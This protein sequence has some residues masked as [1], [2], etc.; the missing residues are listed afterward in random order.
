MYFKPFQIVFDFCGSFGP[1]ILLASH[2]FAHCGIFIGN[3]VTSQPGAHLGTLGHASPFWSKKYENSRQKRALNNIFVILGGHAWPR[4]WPIQ[5][6]FAK[7]TL[8]IV[9]LVIFSDHLETTCRRI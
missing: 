5:N 3:G 4:L 7:I 9:K 8:I 2:E 6:N 1:D